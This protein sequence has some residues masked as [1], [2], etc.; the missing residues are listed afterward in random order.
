MSTAN[1][2]QR[3]G[4]GLRAGLAV[5][6]ALGAAVLAVDVA[7]WRYVRIDLTAARSNTVDLAVLDV[8]DKLPESVVV[9]VFL[10]PLEYP[11]D[12][13]FQ[14][15]RG[16][17]LEWLA[18][19]QQARRGKVDVR[20]HDSSDFEAI[21]DRLRELGSEGS[22]KLVVSC[23]ARRAELELFGELC[24]VS[25]GN[26]TW[27]MVRYLNE[28]DI[29][30]VVDPRTW[31]RNGPFRPASFQEFHGEEP[32]TQA[33]LK[34]SS[35]S[36]PR[37][38]FASGHG[39]PALEGSEPAGLSRLKAALERDGFEVSEWDPAKTPAVPDDC[40][41]LA[42]IGAKQA[43]Q[44]RTRATVSAWAEAGGRVLAAPDVNELVEERA[45][46][47]VELLRASPFGVVTRKGLVC[48]P[49]VGY[50]G[51]KLDGSPDCA[52]I[53]IDERGMQPGNPL[54]EPLRMRGRRV[55]FSQ[56][57]SFDNEALQTD[58]G[59]LQVVV[60]SPVD[61]WRDLDYDYRYNPA[62]GEERDRYPL[63]MSKELRAA[64]GE[65]GSV[66]QGRLVAVASAFFFADELLDL[67]R[68]FALN[69]FNWLAEREY[70]LSVSPLQ[71]SQSFL[72]VQRSR[73]RPIL[74]Y[75]LG[76]GLPALCAAIGLAIAWARRS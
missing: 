66:R 75:A 72:D 18:V 54:T 56:S 7:D 23:G 41:V 15:A 60:S 52:H 9:D 33:L 20:V 34:V 31:Q 45:G 67:N 70:R 57:P 29:P 63:V 62:Q 76:L 24:T 69:A 42:L 11:Y 27:E 53:V 68:D 22:N 71:R 32:I 37:V 30:G 35:G 73:A 8:I 49:Y 25:W 58:S 36:A 12:G 48:Q 6:L 1:L 55:Q 10:R 38:Y 46:G 65:D 43:Y 3:V 17:V 47:I 19:V 13:V 5:V 44:E 39:E 59:L 74:G 16:K 14:Q 40:D 26:P 4:I 64:K 50:S 21:Q 51:E 61:A 28:Q 2:R